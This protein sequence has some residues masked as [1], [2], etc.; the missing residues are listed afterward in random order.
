MT[1]PRWVY[2]PALVALAVLGIPLL[3]LLA[4]VNWPALPALITSAEGSAAL[5]LSLRSSL[6][7]TAI[8]VVLGIPLALALVSLKKWAAPLRAIVIV[9]M[10]MPPVV[11]GLA[12]LAAFGRRSPL[13]MWVPALG[14]FFAFSTSAVVLAQVFV[15]LPFLVLSAESALKSLDVRYLEAAR[16]LGAGRTKILFRVVLPLIAPAVFSGTALALARALGEFGATLTFAGSLPGVTR[17]M[18][19]AIYLQREE[20]P[21]LALALAA[22]LLGL[23]VALV[24][25]AG[26]TPR[27]IRR[28]RLPLRLPTRRAAAP[29]SGDKVASQSFDLAGRTIPVRGWTAVIGPNGA[30]KTTLL[31][32][33]AGLGSPAQLRRAVLLTQYPA[34]FPHLSVLENVRFAC[35]DNSRARQELE[36]VH[37]ADLADRYPA[38]ISGGQAARVA[39]ARAL[40]ASPEVLLL[41]EPLAAVDP[42]AAGM[43][44]DVLR[45]R[46]TDIPVIMVTHDAVDVA[47]LADQ[48]LV[49]ESGQVSAFGSPVDILAQ[50]ATE[51][52]A[53]F[54]G[55][56]ALTGV[57]SAV[58][59]VVTV[60]S[61]IGAISGIASQPMQ[62]GRLATAL[63]SPRSV[64]LGSGHSSA[65]T[66]LTST[67]RSTSHHGSY[68]RIALAAGEQ[69]MFAD[70]TPTSA[71]ELRLLPGDTV[72]VQI[73]ALQV[74]VV[75]WQLGG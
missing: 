42:A 49:I 58:A 1:P 45:R 52:L 21:D 11:G 47:T 25:V 72:A 2:L 13:G 37:A 24:A 74:T 65:R 40:A 23:A 34:L 3:A 9:P 55:L 50:P 68:V 69:T 27:L 57:V 71:S 14:D 6:L 22:I 38:D 62:V 17:T 33:L 12:L 26:A 8:I 35:G 64:V 54:A 28:F 7:A 59:D 61:A 10:T 15:G 39:L 41:D 16:G 60:E 66:S 70:I 43:L 5:A 29:V 30:G 18:P 20:N 73:K 53:E 31:R 32:A 67:V 48:V 46:L 19:L 4:D 44:R 51:Y 63:F 75:P 56:S 36:A